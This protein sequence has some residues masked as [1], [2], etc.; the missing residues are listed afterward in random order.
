VHDIDFVEPL[1]FIIFLLIDVLRSVKIVGVIEIPVSA[2]VSA[3]FTFDP[4]MVVQVVIKNIE[5][6][7]S[8]IGYANSA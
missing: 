5:L 8:V 6:F 3:L 1:N 2:P 4:P 7:L